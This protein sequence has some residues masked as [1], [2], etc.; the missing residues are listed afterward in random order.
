M[1]VTIQNLIPNPRD[2]GLA[3]EG[4]L[5]FSQ[6]YSGDFDVNSPRSQ[7]KEH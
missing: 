1:I 4:K 6:T 7:F 2:S 5:S 3:D